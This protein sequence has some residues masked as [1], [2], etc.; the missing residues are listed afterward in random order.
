MLLADVGNAELELNIN[1]SKEPNCKNPILFTLP[2]TK[3]R[4]PM[5]PFQTIGIETTNEGFARLSV[6]KAC[7]LQ[8]TSFAFQLMITNHSI[9]YFAPHTTVLAGEALK[10][11]LTGGTEYSIMVNTSG[12][13]HDDG[14]CLKVSSFET[15]KHVNI[16]INEKVKRNRLE[17]VVCKDVYNCLN[18]KPMS[19]DA[20]G[21]SFCEEC[22]VQFEKNNCPLCNTSFANTFVNQALR[23]F[24]D[25][26][27]NVKACKRKRT[28]R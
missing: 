11:R 2:F 17:C 5:Y 14:F 7:D 22:L 6:D 23:D 20:C 27:D 8:K 24:I 9:K 16:R 3:G 10:E 19:L 12:I 28:G 25:G 26:S 1:L 21:H 15:Y 13:L 4:V 18:K